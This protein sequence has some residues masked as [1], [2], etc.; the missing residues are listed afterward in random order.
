MCLDNI[1]RGKDNK[2]YNKSNIRWKVLGIYGKRFSGI[3]VS[4][5]YKLGVKKIALNKGSK[6]AQESDIGF[7]VFVHKKDAFDFAAQKEKV[8]IVKVEVEGFNASGTWL[9]AYENCKSETWKYMKI[10]EVF[11]EKGNNI[12]KNYK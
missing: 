4:T 9:R 11:D 12:T 8:V 7:H 6:N 5:I 3:Y 10:V 2:P 1:R